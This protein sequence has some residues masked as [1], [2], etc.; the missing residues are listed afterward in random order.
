VVLSACWLQTP[1]FGEMTVQSLWTAL[2]EWGCGQRVGLDAFHLRKRRESDEKHHILA[3]DLSLWVME[4][5]KSTVLDS[6]HAD[7]AV[8]LVYN[9][10]VS[11]LLLGFRLVFVM[12][13]KRRSSL[14]QTASRGGSH[15][16]STSRRCGEVL[17]L[18]GVTVLEAEAGKVR[19]NYI[20]L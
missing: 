1:C 5:L 9:R 16:M 19:V 12:E 20:I 8:H 13:G 17:R 18:L 7:P 3:V 15:F 14:G 10:T 4:G 2:D 11:L 6:L